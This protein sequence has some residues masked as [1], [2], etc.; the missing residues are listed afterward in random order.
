MINSNPSARLVKHI[1]RS[2][3]RLS[4]NPRV[5]SI[6]K[7]NLPAILKDK[8]FY[9][10]LDDSSKR[11]LHN[12]LKTLS[13]HS[14]VQSQG[15]NSQV[16][17]KNQSVREGVSNDRTTQGVIQGLHGPVNQ[18][19]FIPSSNLQYINSNF[20]GY[21]DV[22]TGTSNPTQQFS[23]HSQNNEYVDYYNMNNMNNAQNSN[24]S[25]SPNFIQHKNYFQ[26]NL[27]SLSNSNNGNHGNHANN[28]NLSSSL[29]SVPYQPKNSQINNL[30]YSYKNGK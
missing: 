16:N 11:W 9:Q 3:A 17:S 30:V 10:S 2:Y 8:N 23:N 5:R 25:T 28:V 15:T 27:N 6:L 12:L 4:E 21:S 19:L 1:I 22:V 20:G 14:N 24:F 7:E 18:N 29:N 26:N 13:N